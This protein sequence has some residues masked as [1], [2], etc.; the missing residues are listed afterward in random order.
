MLRGDEYMGASLQTL[1]DKRFDHGMILAQTP[2][3][4]VRIAEG[5]PLKEING[6]MATEGADLLVNGLRSGVHVPPHVDGGWMAGELG[7]RPLQHAPKM[8]K[9]ATQVDWT[10]WKAVD[11]RRRLQISR[12]V[13]TTIRV[14]QQAGEGA[15]KERRVIFHDAREVPVTEVTGQRA[16]LEA[17]YREGGGK[18]EQ[19]ERVLSL[20]RG[21]G[22]VFLLLPGNTW[23]CCQRA[24]LE[25]KPERAAAT[26]LKDLVVVKDEWSK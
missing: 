24:T 8:S 14:P 17:V 10:A 2:R 21:T 22:D 20:D 19:H 15:S 1:D 3:P 5:T 7:D 4:G 9:A 16:T 23:I 13:W 11:W 6:L 25:G 18:G 26:A 12:A